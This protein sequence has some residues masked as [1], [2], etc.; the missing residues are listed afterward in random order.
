MS[1]MHTNRHHEAFSLCVKDLSKG[2]YGSSL[3]G[4]DGCSNEILLDQGIQVPEDILR[5]IPDWVFPYG[6]GFPARHQKKKE[7]EK[8]TQPRDRVH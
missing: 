7:K 8:S 2:Q 4:M 6:T 1:G 3:Y 5:A